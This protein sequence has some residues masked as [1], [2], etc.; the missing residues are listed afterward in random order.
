MT[1]HSGSEPGLY[2]TERLSTWLQATHDAS[3]SPTTRAWSPT[4]T[5]EGLAR[6]PVSPQPIPAV[7]L[8]DFA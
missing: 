1:R 3:C 8:G 6:A 5:A 7:A 2:R 4:R